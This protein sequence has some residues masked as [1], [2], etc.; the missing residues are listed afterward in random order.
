MHL[1]GLYMGL[2]V[3]QYREQTVQAG[4][5]LFLTSDGLPELFNPAKELLDSERIQ[6]I[7]GEVAAQPAA[8]I[9]EHLRGAAA[10]WAD[11]RPPE[12]DLTLLVLKVTE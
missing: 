3:L 7:L 9:V 8:A 11:G 2:T 6:D 10:Q 1:R 4:D 5:T 12:D